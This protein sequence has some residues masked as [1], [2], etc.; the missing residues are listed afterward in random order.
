MRFHLI[1]ISISFLVISS[2][3]AS[4]SYSK[5]ELLDSFHTTSAYLNYKKEK[6]ITSQVVVIIQ[7]EGFDEAFS[8]PNPYAAY[9]FEDFLKTKTDLSYSSG[10]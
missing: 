1:L 8:F 5:K 3:E 7:V 9:L 10:Y 2:C 6:P 4:N